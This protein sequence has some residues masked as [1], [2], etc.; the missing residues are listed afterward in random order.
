MVEQV[1]AVYS[2]VTQ[3]KR[4]ACDNDVSSPVDIVEYKINAFLPGMK[5]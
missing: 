1:E 3:L 4:L 5:I 2:L